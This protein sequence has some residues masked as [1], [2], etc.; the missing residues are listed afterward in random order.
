MQF[1]PKDSD[2]KIY[3][4]WRA[5][6]EA[7]LDYADGGPRPDPTRAPQSMVMRLPGTR[8]ARCS[9]IP[10]VSA[11]LRLYPPHRCVRRLRWRIG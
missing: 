3:Q 2:P 5:R 9:V 1:P 7:L 4:E 6:V 10:V 11:K 8:R